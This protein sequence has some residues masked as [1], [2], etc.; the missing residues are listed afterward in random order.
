MEI[1]QLKKDVLGLS[2]PKYDSWA[3][4][5]EGASSNLGHAGERRVVYSSLKVR[6]TCSFCVI[7]KIDK[8]T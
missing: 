1:I 6:G 3:Y 8:G 2:A 4:L 7:N 5:S